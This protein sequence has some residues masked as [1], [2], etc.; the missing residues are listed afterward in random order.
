MNRRWGRAAVAV[1]CALAI[2]ISPCLWAS[3]AL[4]AFET[5]YEY[6][7]ADPA[8]LTDLVVKEDMSS[9]GGLAQS[10]RLIP[11]PEYPYTETAESFKKDVDRYCTLYNLNEGSQ[12]AAYIYFFDVLGT[13]ASGVLSGEISDDDIRIYLE[14][15][16]VQYPDEPD[17]DER[18]MARALY[19]AMITG[20]FSG[21]VNGVPLEE[22]AVTYL[23]SLTG[24]NMDTLRDWLPEESVLSLDAYLLAASRLALWTGG[25]DVTTET[26]VDDIFRLVAVMT[27]EQM[28]IS[29]DSDLSFDELKSKYMAAM[30]GRKF[31]VSVDGDRL[32]RAIG[33]DNVAF[34]MLQLLGR[35]GGVSIREDNSTYEEAF[36]LVAENT[37]YF[38]L[39]EDE[40][41]AD[42]SQYEL[43]LAYKR[44]SIWL[45]PTSAVSHNSDYVVTIDVN[46]FAVRDGYYTEVA[47]DPEKPTQTLA[48]GVT[49]SSAKKTSRFVYYIDLHQGKLEKPAEP[50]RPTENGGLSPS[51]NPFISS[52]SIVAQV[53]STFGLDP[54]ILAYYGSAL[55]S[56]APVTQRVL[57]YISPSFDAETLFAEDLTAGQAAEGVPVLTDD[58]YR[59]VLDEIGTLSDVAIRGIDGTALPEETAGGFDLSRYVTFG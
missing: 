29:A 39:E 30:L 37:D 51:T 56:F 48:V 22:A 13:Q 35:Q 25:Y 47:V 26:P 6:E 1:L 3:A 53:M 21:G 10:C 36:D 58:E 9:V 7:S 40:F 52:E 24:M 19:T 23:S 55:Y 43:T 14:S 28:G 17:S 4:F 50:S 44:S 42:I 12:R 54:S 15:M 8:W 31:D 59:S 41:Y 18:I 20:A 38:K 11:K 57:T 45:Y 16:G 2:C 34:Y 5:Q 27:I 33:E 32:A 49:A 46:G